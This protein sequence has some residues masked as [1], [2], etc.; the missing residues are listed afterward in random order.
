MA[1]VTYSPIVSS[2]SGKTSGVVFSSWKGRAYIRKLIIPNNPQSAAQQAVRDSLN[3]CITCWRS[4]LTVLRTWLDVTQVDDRL[5]GYNWYIKANRAAEQAD[6]VHDV[7]P[8]SPLMPTLTGLALTPGDTQISVAFDEASEAACTKVSIYYR[9]QAT[10]V[11]T[12]NGYAAKDASPVVLS[13][14]TNDTLYEVAAVNTN[15]DY[16]IFGQS[17]SAQ[18]TPAA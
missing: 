6:T 1:R 7:S 10:K 13:S 5:S 17:A 3:P 2:A 18:A 9:K 8:F 15:D 14:L 11:W 16:S 4:L 12:H